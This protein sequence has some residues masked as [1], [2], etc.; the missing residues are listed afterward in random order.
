M[1]SV[2]HLLKNYI[3]DLSILTNKKHVNVKWDDEALLYIIN[4]L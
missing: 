1:C 4:D 2:R 3:D